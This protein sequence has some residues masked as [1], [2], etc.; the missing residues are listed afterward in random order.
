M[1]DGEICRSYL[2][3]KNRRKQIGVLAE[4]SLR[5]QKQIKDVLVAGG[6]DLGASA[7]RTRKHTAK[8]EASYATVQTAYVGKGV[9]RYVYK[10]YGLRCR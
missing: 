1:T 3:A 8:D 7:Q 4:L 5:S 2:G 6:V 9:R 10:E